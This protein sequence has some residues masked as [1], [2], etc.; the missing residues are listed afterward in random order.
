MVVERR[1]EWREAPSV[2]IWVRASKRVSKAKAE[3]RPGMPGCQVTR[4]GWQKGEHY[5][6]HGGNEVWASGREGL[7]K[8]E[9]A[10]AKRVVR[11]LEEA[12]RDWATIGPDVNS[13]MTGKGI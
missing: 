5:M 6:E 11:N 4:L 1:R 7:G 12:T 8:T 9:V 2:R 10:R 13:D 3:V